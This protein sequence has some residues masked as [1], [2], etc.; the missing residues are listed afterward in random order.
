[1]R[2]FWDCQE[3][4]GTKTKNSP[5]KASEPHISIIGHI[6]VGELQR[7]L[8]FDLFTNGFVNRFLLVLVKRARLLPFGGEP[9]RD[10]IA[11]LARRT[12]AVINR[13]R[14][15]VFR[16]K[17]TNAGRERWELAYQELS[18]ELVGLV[19]D[20]LARAEAQCARLALLY[21]LLDGNLDIAPVHIEAALAVW[22]YCEAST[23]Y[24][25]GDRTGDPIADEILSSLRQA[26]PDGMTRTEIYNL[27]GRHRSV[28]RTGDALGL[29]LRNGKVQRRQRSTA[30]RPIEIWSMA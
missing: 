8:D 25:F 9:E 24:L 23:R 28:Q 27:L 4:V 5:T 15:S 20:A 13:A 3:R 2:E 12:Q 18:R 16:V 14:Q 17:F 22:R 21:C 11:A 19:D 30:G 26:G 1:M 7:R 6:T 10:V 29:L